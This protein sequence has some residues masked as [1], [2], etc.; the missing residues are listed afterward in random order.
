MTS[1]ASFAIHPLPVVGPL[2]EYCKLLVAVDVPAHPNVELTVLPHGSY[3]F[4]L[5][6][7]AGADPF[8]RRTERGSLPH[9]C[10]LRRGSNA[11]RPLGDCRT[12]YAQLTPDAGLLLA[13]QALPDATDPRVPLW[14]LG[15]QAALAR[16][17][18]AMAMQPDVQGQLLALGCWLE[19][20]IRVGSVA[21][22]ARRAT[23]V[24]ARIA[25]S[26]VESIEAIARTECMSRR[27]IERD[28]RSWLHVSPKHVAQVARTQAAM[29]LGLAGVP[30]AEAA[31]ALGFADQS[32]M[33]HSV[34]KLARI[35]PAQL[36]RRA[37]TDFNR[38][39]SGLPGTGLVYLGTPMPA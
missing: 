24:A 26:P 1:P 18:D 27:Q 30:L 17:E 39:L 36:V 7:A 33:T 3:V 16:L 23:R 13:G 8:A 35:A 38:P 6:F 9:L 31:H 11:Y 32:H 5:M 25:A 4:S 12:F 22:Q 10:G 19:D 20:R 2:R 37:R 34:K 21:E 14:Q 29:R 28:F 15:G